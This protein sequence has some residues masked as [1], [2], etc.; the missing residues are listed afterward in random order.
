MSARAY[1]E[2][3]ADFVER[4]DFS[5]AALRWLWKELVVIDQGVYPPLFK[6]VGGASAV[7]GGDTRRA[8]VMTNTLFIGILLWSLYQIGLKVHGERCG[9]LSAALVMVYPMVVGLSRAYMLE[10]SLLALTALSAYLLLYSERFRNRLYTILFGVSLGLGMLAKPVF[11]TYIIAPLA[12]VVALAAVEVCRKGSPRS[13]KWRRLL[14]ILVALGVGALVAGPWYVPNLRSFASAT[15]SVSIRN[16][17]EAERL[18]IESIL[19][20]AKALVFSQLGL[21]FA[22]LF[23]FGLLRLVRWPAPESAWFFVAMLLGIYI[24]HCLVPHKT[25]RQDVGILVPVSVVSAV[26]LVSLSG[27]SRRLAVAAAMSFAVVQFCWFTTPVLASAGSAGPEWVYQYPEFDCGA[28]PPSKEDWRI[29]QVLKL[30]GDE[31]SRVGVLC[32]H[33]TINGRTLEYYA[34]TMGHASTMIQVRSRVDNFH[35]RLNKYDYVITKSDWDPSY[36]EALGPPWGEADLAVLE[37][38]ED[39]LDSFMVVESLELPDG[40]ELHIYKYIAE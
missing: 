2:V 18:G 34:L 24:I 20:Y 7:L 10:F 22:A 37:R 5:G 29:E 21:P 4:G 6:L 26:G 15:T 13:Q 12:Y 25:I 38:F 40:S 36:I 16:T 23:V 28:R 19:Y 14:W 9:M 31:P 17:L 30:L 32:D 35:S 33:V 27:L 3:M 39:G 8:L 1:G 11:L